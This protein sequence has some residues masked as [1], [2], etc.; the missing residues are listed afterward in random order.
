[1]EEQAIS[2]NSRRWLS[3]AGMCALLMLCVILADG[4]VIAV[5]TISRE[6]GGT[7]NQLAWAVSGFSLVACLAVVSG[8]LG[9]MHGNRKVLTGGALV[10]VAG[11]AF[12]GLSQTANELILGRVLQGIGSIAIWTSALSLVTLQFPPSER[13]RAL[14]R[15]C[16]LYTSPSPRD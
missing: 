12:G 9:D 14:T 13:P 7:A 3:L 8:R 4:F 11:S 6:L 10:L 1:M 15:C 16:L 2:H 5:P